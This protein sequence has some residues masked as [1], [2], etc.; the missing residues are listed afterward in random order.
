MKDY[1][2]APIKKLGFGFMRLPGFE[3]K[4][5]SEIDYELTN[6]M[7]DLYLENGFTYFD[8]AFV[9]HGGNSEVAIRKALTERHDRSKFQVTTKLPLWQELSFD[10][11]RDMTK[12]SLE[13]TGL[14]HF[15][16]YFLHGIGPERV[17]MIEKMKAFEYLRELKDNGKSKNVGFSYHGDGDSL[18]SL[19]DKHAEHID[20]VQLQINYLDWEET[21]KKCYDAAIAHDVGIIVMSPLKGGSLSNFTPEVAGVFKKANPEAS[22][23]SWGLRFPM[24]LEGV[25]T[26]LS[27]MSNLQQ[28]ED[29]I[30]IADTMGSLSADEM[31]VIDEAMTEMKKIPTIPC[32]MCR[33]C[34]DCCP[35][36]INSPSIIGLLNE[37]TLYQNLPGAKRMYNMFTGGAWGG[38]PA[39]SS[40]CVDCGECERHCPQKIKIIEAHKDAVKLFE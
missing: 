15:N 14:D 35:K 37:Y 6:K 12:T 7:T 24:H 5:D 27:G 19:L 23:T 4:P 33:Y 31:K 18:N 30:K 29:N 16:L 22:V 21:A 26:V 36:K 1:F 20:I 17:E 40:D 28:V 32:T 38:A 8:T 9:Y 3:G 2:G 13:R 34:V 25:I 10:Q 39:R 11:M